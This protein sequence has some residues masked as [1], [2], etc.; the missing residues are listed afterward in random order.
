MTT[1]NREPV[2]PFV[3]IGRYVYLV[4]NWDE[5]REDAPDSLLLRPLGWQEEALYWRLLHDAQTEAFATISIRPGY[6]IDEDDH[7]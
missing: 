1:R 6:R 5:E 3:H 7:Q 4:V 2:P